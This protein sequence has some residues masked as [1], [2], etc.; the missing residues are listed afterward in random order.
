MASNILILGAGIYQVPLI[1]RVKARGLQTVVASIPGNYPGIQLADK[2]LPI[3][4]T[5]EQGIVEAAQKTKAT[6]VITTGTDVALRSI[7]AA[8]DA[9]GLAGPT[10]AMAS[11]ATNKATMKGAFREGGV[12]SAQFVKATN[13][14]EAFAAWDALHPNGDSH[15]LMVKCPDRSGSRGISLTASRED[16][17]P[18]FIDAAETSICG[19]A[20]IEDFISG[21]E[22]GLD[23][24]VN[25]DGR[26]EFIAYHDKI[27][28]SNGHTDVPVGHIMDANFI[29]RCEQETDLR[30][31]AQLTAIA[32]GMQSCFFNMDVI[33]DNEGHAWIIE[34][35]VRAGAT[36]IPEIIGAYYG[37][38]YY[39]SMIDA[40][41]GEKP[42]FP[43]SPACGAAEGRLL[44][45]ERDAIAQSV[46]VDDIVKSALESN[47]ASLSVLLDYAP[48][49]KLPAFENGTSRIGQIVCSGA[50]SSSV[51]KTIERVI[52]ILET[53]Y[54]GR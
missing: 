22:V 11:R 47:G 14:A 23:G 8:N 5:D 16:V 18:A 45:T 51:S 46:D 38:N 28:R 48:G 3:N 7:G 15:P 44:L 35:G 33:V 53:I 20:V 29:R 37:F 17:L 13:E 1:N 4:T 12:R 42:V 6:A 50:D 49:L 40:A 2:F 10:L 25:A 39:D 34:A 52:S 36:C 21:H 9:L 19:Y 31:Q 27:V 26:I 32:I 30:E 24:Y 41:L 43:T 54:I